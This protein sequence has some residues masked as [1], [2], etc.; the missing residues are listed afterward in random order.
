MEVPPFNIT[1][2]L[3]KIRTEHLSE[4]KLANVKSGAVL[5]QLEA[6]AYEQLLMCSMQAL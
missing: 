4:S 3:A 5:L 6:L 1:N 2:V